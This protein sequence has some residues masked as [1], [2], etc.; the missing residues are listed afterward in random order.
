MSQLDETD[1][2]VLGVLKANARLSTREIARK[3][4]VPAA[5]VYKR[6]KRMEADGIIKNYTVTLDNTKLGRE[7][8]A[9]ILVR[10][11][12]GANYDAMMTEISRREE[13]EEV[14]AMAGD[15]DI[16]LRIRSE[17]MKGLDKFIFEYLRRFPD[18]SQTQTLMVF[19]SWKDG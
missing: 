13:V 6:M 19:R 10:T 1:K 5:T 14:A 16:L 9:Y 18:V 4:G 7:T 12:P 15:F 8:L 3:S 2:A 11:K 17:N